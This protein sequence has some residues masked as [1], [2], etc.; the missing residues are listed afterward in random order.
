MSHLTTIDNVPLDMTKTTDSEN[1]KPLHSKSL[2]R[3]ESIQKNNTSIDANR[4]ALSEVTVN[5]TQSVASK[6]SK[7]VSEKQ[8]EL[9][10]DKRQVEKPIFLAKIPRIR[11]DASDL[12]Y[13][14]LKKRKIYRDND[15][16]PVQENTTSNIIN[17][18]L[19]KIQEE[20]E[21]NLTSKNENGRLLTKESATANINIDT[22]V[23]KKWKNLDSSEINDICMVVEYTDDIFEHLYKRELETTTEINYTTDPN[24]TYQLRESL[25]TILVDWL[26]EVHEKF[27]LYPETLFLAI[28]LMDRFLSKNKVTLSKLQLLAI[29]ALFISAKFEEINLPKLSDYSYITDGAAS[30]DDIK[31]AEMFM[32]KSLEFNLGW[33]NPMNFIRRLSKADGY[34]FK[35]RNLAKMILEFAICSNIF[36]NVKPSR[37][38]AISMY[39]AR[40]ITNRNQIYWDST[41][42]HY[43]GGIDPLNDATF[44]KQCFSLINEMKKENN[45][46]SLRRKFHHPKLFSLYNAL[47]NWCNHYEGKLFPN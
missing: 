5:T 44:K 8:L 24:Y 11:R 36:I 40:R 20:N 45:Y 1:S 43:S 22:V 46:D 37:I 28:N 23:P 30:N 26:V 3:N 33:P 41:F 39:I 21:M 27:E 6:T 7:K 16:T 35:T 13:V 9:S 15:D 38:S 18:D 14:N 4:I 25:R 31:S 17:L 19:S 2:N 10:D 12:T 42:E 32:L 34:D 29:T 47:Q